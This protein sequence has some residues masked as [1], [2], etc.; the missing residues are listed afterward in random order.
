MDNAAV[1]QQIQRYCRDRIRELESELKLNYESPKKCLVAGT[2]LREV[3]ALSDVI[4][5]ILRTV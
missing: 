4:L 2:Q 3:T 1:I 5:H